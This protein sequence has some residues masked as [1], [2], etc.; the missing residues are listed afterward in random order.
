MSKDFVKGCEHIVIESN[1]DFIQLDNCININSE[2]IKL[3]CANIKGLY[4]YLVKC[5]IAG[6]IKVVEI[7]FTKLKKS[8]LARF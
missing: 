3:V 2:F 4:C 8:F 1:Y 5:L 6:L 7:T